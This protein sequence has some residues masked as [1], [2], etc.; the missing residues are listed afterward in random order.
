MSKNIR[1]VHITTVH[2][3]FDSRIF[4]KECVSLAREGFEVSLI[5]SDDFMNETITLDK[6]SSVNIIDIGY[7]R[8]RVKKLFLST[9]RAYKTAKN[10]KADIYHFHDPDFLVFA[11][12]LK[13]KTNRVYF[14]SHE[15]FPALMKQREY[16]PNYLRA[17][18]Y[19]ITRRLEKYSTKRITG[20]FTATDNI[21][22]KFLG[23]GVGFAQTIKN[24][25]ILPKIIETKNHRPSENTLCYVGGLI[26]IR[27]VREMV[28][29]TYNSGAKLL[30]AGPFDSEVY[31]KEIMS[32][33]EWECV[34]YFG[35]IPHI[36][37]GKLIYSNSNIGFVILHD[38]PNH[39]NS[40]PIK[41][42]EYMSYGLPI[43]ASK[44]IL[45]CKE[46]IEEIG[47]GIIVDPLNTK[48]IE[49]A[50]KT[51]LDNKT[52]A[53]EMGERGRIASRDI[54]NWKVEERKLIETYKS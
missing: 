48:E 23:Y 53:I 10:L 1:V 37:I 40:I 41:F 39:R 19:F 26:P 14:D 9:Y 22:D 2:K 49:E 45:F 3:R 44:D 13:N 34:E 43:I 52:L 54:Y 42:L 27:G 51:L 29:T 30:L 32:L 35:F 36:K 38:A 25:P 24:Y 18:L 47:C 11:S 50:I 6:N 12:F 20:V 5:V 7:E 21:R 4:H 15:D 8:N 17:I 16:I 33:K 46:V 31:K 28:I